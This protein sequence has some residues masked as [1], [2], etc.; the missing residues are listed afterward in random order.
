MPSAVDLALVLPRQHRFELRDPLADQLAFVAQPVFEQ[1]VGARQRRGVR[2]LLAR[3]NF[4]RLESL[5][6]LRE[7]GVALAV[8]LI[9]DHQLAP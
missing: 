8:F 1:L 3:M 9:A 2:G 5:A 4:Q 6:P 7:I